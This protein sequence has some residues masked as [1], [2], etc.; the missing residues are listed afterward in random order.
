MDIYTMALS[1]QQANLARATRAKSLVAF[2][3]K[4][5]MTLILMTAFLYGANG[6]RVVKA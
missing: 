5:A 6:L 4:L 2:G 1:I 3:L